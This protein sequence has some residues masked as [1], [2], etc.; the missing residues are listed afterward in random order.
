MTGNW[1]RWGSDDERGAANL[2][3]PKQVCDA[4]GLVRD[5]RVIPLGQ[6][7]SR[8]TP[9][10]AH[11][12]PPAHFMDR[13]GGDSPPGALFGYADDTLLMAAHSGTHLDSLAHVWS[14]DQLYNGFPASAVTSRGV[15][16]C[17]IDQLGPLVGRGVLLDVAAALGDLPAGR[18]I[19]RDELAETAD[20]AG[21]TLAPGDL[22]LLRTRWWPRAGETPD[23]FDGEPGPGPEAAAWLADADIALVGADNY[24]L[25]VQPADRFPAHRILLRD[26]GITILEGLD[27]EALAATGRTTFLLVV[28]PLRLLGASGSPVNPVAVL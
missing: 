14:E 18:E 5:G 19:T 27:L 26:H 17:G 25:E 11:R 12:H 16:H 28:A 6:P 1:G 3:G 7:L 8:H 15:R 2:L 23:Y 22:V 21:V 9:T 10:P 4:A 20:R 13:D 24:A